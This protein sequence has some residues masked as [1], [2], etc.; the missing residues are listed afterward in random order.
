[1]INAF[2]SACGKALEI[3]TVTCGE[4][5]EKRPQPGA[6]EADKETAP[7]D[8][9]LS[10][11]YMKGISDGLAQGMEERHD[12]RGLCNDVVRLYSLIPGSEH[13]GAETVALSILA[14]LDREDTAE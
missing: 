5:C 9:I 7:H 10:S 4:C 12:I 13:R 8:G 6:V 11:M 1:M 3:R 14:I 2:C